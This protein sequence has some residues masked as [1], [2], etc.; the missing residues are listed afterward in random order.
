MYSNQVIRKSKVKQFI[1]SHLTNCSCLKPFFRRESLVN[2]SAYSK[3]NR[4][5]PIVGL[6]I[7]RSLHAHG[8][9]DSKR[10]GA[11]LAY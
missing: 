6:W 9:N 10:G 8:T 4:Q 2:R 5:V 1:H 7:I 11:K 3:I